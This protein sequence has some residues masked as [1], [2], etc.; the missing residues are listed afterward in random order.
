MKEI[1]ILKLLKENSNNFPIYFS[2][3]IFNQTINIYTLDV[4]ERFI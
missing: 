2:S 3:K 1:E 4:G